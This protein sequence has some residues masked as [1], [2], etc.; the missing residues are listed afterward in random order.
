MASSKLLLAGLAS[1]TL[2]LT[3]CGGGSD[4]DSRSGNPTPTPAPTSNP[5]PTPTPTATPTPTPTPTPTAGVTKVNGP[6]DPVQEQVVDGVI[7]NELAGQLPEPFSTFT[8]CTAASLNQL[9]DVPDAILAGAEGLANGADPFD[10][11]NGSA[12]DA[13]G[14]LERF[15]ASL[16]ATL[17]A[18]AER[19]S[20]DP[21]ADATAASGNPLA[22]TPLA[23]VGTAL[24]GLIASFG[25]GSEDPNLTTLSTAVA[26]ALTALGVALDGLPAEITSA[27]VLGGVVGTLDTAIDDVAATLAPFGAYDGPATATAASTA[28]NNLLQGVLLNT[29]PVADIDPAVATQIGDGI[30]TLTATLGSGLGQVVT[31]LFN[32]GLNGVLSPVL[33]PVEGLLAAIAGSGNP[34]DGVLAAFAGDATGNGVDALLGAILSAANGTPLE[35]LVVAAGGSPASDSPLA[36]LSELQAQLAGLDTVLGTAVTQNDDLATSLTTI[37]NTL[38]GDPADGSILGGLLGGLL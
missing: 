34:L 10:A 37:L 11:F 21:D 9:V 33:D 25:D 24:E 35:N 19:G 5:T 18:M 14:A 1:T 32:E 27:P 28:L 13:Q 29:I 15:A 30:N 12:A 17:V 31:P 8:L 4:N 3:A 23:P 36:V 7:A 22:G 26:P 38:L 20:C 2:L 6:L 16:Q